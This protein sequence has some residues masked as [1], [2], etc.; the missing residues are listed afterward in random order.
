MAGR[1]A[2]QIGDPDTLMAAALAN[3]RGLF[4]L[5]G[6]V[7]P[8]RVA[9]LE[10]AL[11][12]AGDSDRVSRAR[13]LG[14][15]ALERTFDGD[16]PNRRAIADVALA[17]AR[18]LGDP[19]TLLD[20]LLRRQFAIWMPDTLPE[21]LTESSEAE[22]LADRIGDPVGRFWSVLT[23]MTTASESANLA[24]YDRCVTELVELAD[25]VGQPA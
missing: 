6:V 18:R 5:A 13:L 16:Y 12:A 10:A 14:L 25:A 2:Q 8:D 22:A 9:L 17:M 20:V 21:R 19:A 24:E 7:D 3:N 11:A 4:S 23:R 1:V 15:L